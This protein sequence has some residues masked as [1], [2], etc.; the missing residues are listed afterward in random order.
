MKKKHSILLLCAMATLAVFCGMGVTCEI[1]LNATNS[2]HV[3]VYDEFAPI[4]LRQEK[5]GNESTHDIAKLGLLDLWKTDQ[6]K[7]VAYAYSMA[8]DY[9][10]PTG[11]SI[12]LGKN[13]YVGVC[14]HSAQLQF[15]EAQL[16]LSY[17]EIENEDGTVTQGAPI[18][19]FYTYDCRQHGCYAAMEIAKTISEEY[20]DFG[21]HYTTSRSESASLF[22]LAADYYAFA[23][24]VS[25]SS[26]I[27][28]GT[29]TLA[30]VANT[31]ICTNNLTSENIAAD[32]AKLSALG[33]RVYTSCYEPEEDHTTH[34]CAYLPEGMPQSQ[35]LTQAT[36]D[37]LTSGSGQLQIDAE[38]PLKNFI[39]AH[40]AENIESDV[41]FSVPTGLHVAI[42]KNGFDFNVPNLENVYVYDCE[43]HVCWGYNEQYIY[44]ALNGS[45]G[46][47]LMMPLWQD[48][49]D[50]AAALMTTM[51]EL[52]PDR[53]PE[54]YV[55]PAGA[56]A[57]MEDF[58][59]ETF[60]VMFDAQS[61]YVLCSNGHTVRGMETIPE[62]ITV[63]DCTHDFS[64]QNGDQV[65]PVTKHACPMIS[66][67]ITSLD[68][69][70]TV[71]NALVDSDG[72][73]AFGEGEFAL[74]LL[75]DV[76]MPGT[77]IIPKGTKL[78]IC[79]NGYTL[80]GA[81]SL[82]ES[83]NPY[84]FFVEYGAELYICDCS[85]ENT[86]KL[87][88]AT[89]DMISIQDSKVSVLS[90]P[91]YNMGVTEVDRVELQGGVGA[92][93]VGHLII[94]DS[95][96]NG[97]F[98]GVMMD[99]GEDDMPLHALKPSIEIHNSTI[100][101]TFAGVFA[102]SGDVD[103]EE[104]QIKAT[105]VGVATNLSIVESDKEKYPG[106]LT[107]DD[108][109]I[110]LSADR[111]FGVDMAMALRTTINAV[112]GVYAGS[113]MTM[114]GDLTIDIDE[115]LLEPYVNDSGKVVEIV[116]TDIYMPAE[117][118][119]EIAEGVVLTDLYDLQLDTKNLE[120]G[121]TSFVVGN[122]D[123]SDHFIMQ[124]GFAGA[125]NAK[126]EY[127]AMVGDSASFMKN[128][129]SINVEV[130]FEGYVRLNF[131]CSFD[132]YAEYES[133][134]KNEKALVLLTVADEK[135]SLDP[136]AMV[137]VDNNTY[138]YS[139]DF[140][141]KDYQD[142]IRVQFTDG[143]YT[144]TGMTS[145]SVEDFLEVSL[146]S[147]EQQI[148]KSDE[149]L[150]VDANEKANWENTQNNATSS[151]SSAVV[152]LTFTYTEAQVAAAKK[153]KEQGIAYKNAI[154]AMLNYCDVA[155]L[156][157]QVDENY[158]A[159]EK[160]FAHKVTET[161]V[162]EITNERTVKESWTTT[163]VAA[164][165]DAVTEETLAQYKPILKAGSVMPEGIS[166]Y[167]MSLVLNAGTYIRVYFA[168]TAEKMAGLTFTIDGKE[169]TAKKFSNGYY[170]LE[171]E[172]L[173]A[174][175]LT[176][177]YE[178]SVT[179][180]KNTYAFAYGAMSYMYGVLS[181]EN[182]DATLVKMAKA[183]WLYATEVEKSIASLKAL[184]G[185]ASNDNV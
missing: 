74:S 20:L 49:L 12:T 39:Y 135:I 146:L 63:W 51:H 81:Q 102:M 106:T 4:T 56:Y 67:H 145:V 17:E 142:K 137:P 180:G 50:M 66:P 94:N 9:T 35:P 184:E 90:S 88:S 79:L 14:V 93:N 109:D 45:F 10:V 154:L 126:G 85:E 156:Q 75:F 80:S 152:E 98:M 55:L 61:N 111:S 26:R 173:A 29:V 99:E 114:N 150:Q 40:L 165:M 127:V 59:L 163:S 182:A 7:P 138:R 13:V 116:G 96:V 121:T 161:V 120:E 86:G 58:D 166:L 185:G 170:Y 177:T 64:I 171:V 159:L 155:A 43:Q 133:F 179:D 112:A 100:N 110:Q 77:M 1:E 108:V 183:T 107:I 168:T 149:I 181:N 160:D 44:E 125:T 23:E 176:K 18:S 52:Q 41:K 174:T 169:V 27:E 113:G 175:D 151:D 140:Y 118:E 82:A 124:E 15:T 144:W 31:V 139:V 134:L 60:P 19:G 22:A 42:C 54:K 136:D 83:G 123:L 117:N 115:K 32:A 103:L 130:S 24:E 6:Q 178:F 28:Q 89:E 36:F 57:L 162:D 5:S 25:L 101:S 73:F 69:T 141:A 68:L 143:T 47:E 8:H 132:A 53:Y 122:R 97:V 2:E 46:N 147:M 30:D 33:V 11:T 71:L 21:Y 105:A 87:V 78:S 167:G 70:P 72:V 148:E 91:I 65:F 76:E 38:N 172:N 34:S 3:C 157:F 158:T 129:M 62:N 16:V 84:M 131:Y 37:M 164:A 128:A 95:M 92:T 104:V 119:I 48:G 153:A